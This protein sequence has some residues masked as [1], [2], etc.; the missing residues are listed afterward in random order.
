[1]R[2]L[3]SLASLPLLQSAAMFAITGMGFVIATLAYGFF[4]DTDEF[5]HCVLMLAL[6][7]SAVQAAPAGLNAL[8]V[9]YNLRSDGSALVVGMAMAGL[10]A[11]ISASVAYFIYDFSVRDIAVLAFAVVAGGT[12]VAA[13]SA[14]QR[15]QHFKRAT[16]L[17]QSAN[18]GL[19][20]AV[21]LMALGWGRN[22]WMPVLMAGLVMLL[23]GTLAWSSVLRAPTDG[24]RLS[25]KYWSQGVSFAGLGMSTEIFW[26][27]DRLL[28][29]PLLSYDDLALFALLAAIALT[30]F[31]MLEMS[32]LST[33]APRLRQAAPDDRLRLLLIDVVLLAVLCAAAGVVLVLVG[34]WIY[35]VLTSGPAAEVS[36]VVAIIVSGFL[37][38]LV[39]LAQGVAVAF[40]T[41]HELGKV[42][43]VSWL[44]V[45]VAV[46]GA[47]ILENQGLEGVVYGVACGWTFKAL[48]T[49][50]LTLRH[51]RSARP[52]VQPASGSP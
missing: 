13:K 2:R 42:H 8:V 23:T 34:P 19:L 5:G 45:G 22:H 10:L 37:R 11:L 6:C 15:R 48:A 43:V 28:L 41:S 24:K 16:L 44:S 47:A 14:L 3:Y 50:G 25:W 33:L 31:R 9:R 49:F 7:L 26:Q 21:V 29:P 27:L 1:M 36:V 17:W 51:L 40:G 39:A 18:A 52:Q 30:P 32:A 4:L 46:A 38:V 20:L 12:A 35:G